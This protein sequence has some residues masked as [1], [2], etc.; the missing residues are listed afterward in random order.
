MLVDK[1]SELGRTVDLN[2]DSSILECL[3]EES[4]KILIEKSSEDLVQRLTEKL[5][6]K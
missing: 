2:I 6:E 1:N 3:L 5:V 4:A